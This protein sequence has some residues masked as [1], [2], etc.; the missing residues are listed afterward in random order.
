M[1]E[2]KKKLLGGC[3]L[4]E[5]NRFSD[6][7]G[8]FAKLFSSNENIRLKLG[9][10]DQVNFVQNP[11]KGTFRGL[12]FQKSPHGERK[13]ITVLSGSIID[14]L[15]CIDPKN[16][17]FGQAVS[18]NLSGDDQLNLLIPEGYAHGYLTT[19]ENTN[20]CYIH[21]GLYDKIS[22]NGVHYSCLIDE[23]S[24]MTEVEINKISSRDC[25]LS[26]WRILKNDL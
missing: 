25:A 26:N 6:D 24:L 23:F 4:L 3:E 16:S 10:V 15:L 21:S 19:R 20:V 5:R 1:F 12:H 8:S 9:L 7:R 2:L 11:I 18:V 17:F 22:E 13:L 14:F